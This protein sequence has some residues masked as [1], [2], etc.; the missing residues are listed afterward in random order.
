MNKQMKYGMSCKTKI[1]TVILLQALL[2]SGC[3]KKIPDCGDP[4]VIKILNE[5]VPKVSSSNLPIN[6]IQIEALIAMINLEHISLGQAEQLK[7]EEDSLNLKNVA[8]SSYSSI[9]KD[10]DARVNYCS[11]SVSGIEVIEYKVGLS[12]KL[13]NLIKQ[14]SAA[15]EAKNDKSNI[16]A[17][18]GA[19][20]YEI[21]FASL[22]VSGPEEFKTKTISKHVDA[23]NKTWMGKLKSNIPGITSVAATQMPDGLIVRLEKSLP[24]SISYTV[25]MTDKEDQVLVRV[26]GN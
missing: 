23:V 20:P 26:I 19:L 10:K 21:A 7:L 4:S 15:I 13:I 9:R 8:I 16:F 1:S 18:M 5:L 2:L 3:G 25:N 6:K 24:S 17:R 14:A 12:E 11:A 22:G